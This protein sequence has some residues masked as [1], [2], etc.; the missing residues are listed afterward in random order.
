[1]T[2]RDQTSPE[3]LDPL[4]EL[5][6]LEGLT[7][8]ERA[9]EALANGRDDLAD[10]VLAA[11]L[12]ED[13]AGRAKVAQARALS[14]DVGLALRDAV[15]PVDVQAMVTSALAACP[16]APSRRSLVWGAAVGVLATLGLLPLAVELPSTRQ[17][18]DGGHALLLLLDTLD[19]L[20][21][22]VPGGWSLV[23]FALALGLGLVLLPTRVMV[24][25]LSPLAALLALLATS[26]V[27]AQRFEG[28][29]PEGERVASLELTDVPRSEALRRVAEAAGL[30][31]VAR[32][33]DDP[34][35][36]L[37]VHGVSVRDALR[38][39]LDDEHEV[40]REGTTLFVRAARTATPAA[41]AATPTEAP[42][43]APTRAM[44]SV[45]RAESPV[46]PERRAFGGDIHVRAEERVR[47]V[48]AFGGD[49]TIA[50]EV[51]EGVTAYGGDV[52]VREGAIVRGDLVATGGDIHVRRGGEVRGRTI[53]TGGEID[54][55]DG[56]TVEHAP[57]TTPRA[58]RAIE[59][60]GAIREIFS[61]AVK[62]TLLFLLG[63]LLLGVFRERHASLARV[64]VERPTRTVLVGFLGMLGAVLLTAVLLITLIGIPGAF[65]VAVGTFVAVYAGIAVTASVL[66]AV[67]PFSSLAGRPVAQ[68][69]VGIV[70]LFGLSLVPVLGGIVSVVVASLGFGAVIT[71]R[72]GGRGLAKSPS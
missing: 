52:E 25:R 16:P 46:L 7:D 34:E 38:G 18:L 30:G 23:A 60:H 4:D 57:L 53:A 68:L 47:S 49:V 61:S 15:P 22:Q 3:L 29:W 50:G 9:I 12:A 11:M 69:G 39:L 71:T 41:P 36:T 14:I 26:G 62:H 2:T 33:D 27:H 59:G 48:V 20:V 6:D 63:L 40:R 72:F 58:S 51:V 56:A 44:V 19:G 42:S 54:V 45:A 28:E 24:R 5:D 55:E 17:V 43:E 21:S 64:M 66:G 1:M 35:V 31:I 70:V 65:V 67:L 32:L 10:A 8:E 13:D 37:H